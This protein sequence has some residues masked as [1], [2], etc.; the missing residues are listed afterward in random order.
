VVVFS[1]LHVNR[2]E[3]RTGLLLSLAA[4]LVAGTEIQ[5]K[6]PI[7]GTRC[8]GEELQAHDLLVVRAEAVVN[9]DLQF[10]LVI[11]T[12][13]QGGSAYGTGGTNVFKEERK[14]VIS[15][16]FTSSVAGPHWVCITNADAYKELDVMLSMKSGVQAKD[17][18]QI[19]KKDHLEPAQ[20]S[21]RKIED[22]LQEYRSNLFYQRRR[23]ERM[24]ETIDSTSDRAL[25]FCILNVC[26]IVA[27]GLVQ[28]YFFRRFFRSK[29]II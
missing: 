16:A 24:R 12:G 9:K 7:A 19:A 10:T 26:L 18:S 3:M 15:H 8:L 28:A 1:F 25:T 22:L 2:S 27:M 17:Y 11:K 13:T 6:I 21:I 5:M 14:S 20:V 4:G 23:D 29:K